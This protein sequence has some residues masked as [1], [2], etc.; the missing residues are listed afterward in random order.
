MKQL[1]LSLVLVKGKINN[2]TCLLFSNDKGFNPNDWS[3]IEVDVEKYNYNWAFA[4]AFECNRVFA[5][6]RY[7]KD[8]ILLPQFNDILNLESSSLDLNNELIIYKIQVF[9]LKLLIS[10]NDFFK[11]LQLNKFCLVSEFTYSMLE[12][13]NPIV[14]N[15]LKQL[16]QFSMSWDDEQNFLDLPIDFQV[17][18][19]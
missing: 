17:K 19:Y 6:M 12:N 7:G 1:N 5:P 16:H 11:Q 2:T 8:F 9:I 4:A 18:Y 14:I 13:N 10:V 3:F 15:I